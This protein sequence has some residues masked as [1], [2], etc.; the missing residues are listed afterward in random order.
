MTNTAQQIGID[1]KC[2]VGTPIPESEKYQI[3]TVHDLANY[4][5]VHNM[6]PLLKQAGYDVDKQ[7]QLE[8]G[9]GELEFT[10]NDSLVSEV[11]S[12]EE[13]VF[14][15]PSTRVDKKFQTPIPDQIEIKDPNGMS[16]ALNNMEKGTD[17]ETCTN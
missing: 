9:E 5:V 1:Y 17:S 4:S 16:D 11:E 13:N 14:K 8:L 15:P 10:D 6:K 3:L 7:V 2:P 12:D